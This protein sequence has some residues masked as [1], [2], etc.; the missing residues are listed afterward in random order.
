[1][2]QVVALETFKLPAD[3]NGYL[4]AYIG[5]MTMVSIIVVVRNSANMGSPKLIQR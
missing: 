1:M 2:F 3:Q 4:M 5:I